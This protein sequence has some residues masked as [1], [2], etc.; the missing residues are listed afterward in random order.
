MERSITL[1]HGVTQGERTV[2]DLVMRAPTA[3]DLLE[4]QEASERPI[5]TPDGWKLLASDSRMGMETLRRQIKRIGEDS[6]PMELATLKTLSAVDL[7]LLHSEAEALDAALI[8]E[9]SRE[10]AERGRSEGAGPG[11]TP[12]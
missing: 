12:G 5:A 6:G 10:V 2:K 4:A 11:D 7:N 9:L 1:H 8:D 3:G